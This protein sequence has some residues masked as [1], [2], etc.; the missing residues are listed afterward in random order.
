MMPLIEIL[1][2]TAVEN[3]SAALGL[4][5][6]EESFEYQRSSSLCDEQAERWTEQLTGDAQTAWKRYLAN[7]D[8]V[9]DA[10]CRLCFARGLS[11]GLSLA[12]L[13]KGE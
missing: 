13:A 1:Y 6:S 11:V 12:A 5:D 4:L 10:E 7:L 8:R 2:Q 3:W 9:R